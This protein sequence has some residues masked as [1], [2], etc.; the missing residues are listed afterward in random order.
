MNYGEALQYIHSVSWLGSRPG[1]SRISELCRRLSDPERG[2]RFIHVAGTNGKGSVSAE[3]AE[4]LTSAGYR[5]GLFT[6]PYIVDFRERIRIGNEMISE[7]DLAE[8]TDCVKRAA[9]DMSDPP[10]EFELITAVAFEYFKRQGCDFVILEAG[11]G[12]RLDSTNVIK[13]P[14]LSVI[15]G[16]ALDHTAVLGPTVADIAREK[17]GIIKPSCPIVLGD[18]PEKARQVVR[19]RAVECASRLAEVDLRRIAVRGVS[20]CGTDITFAP[21][22]ERYD[23]GG[24]YRLALLGEYQTANAAT[25]LT[26]VEELRREGV[27]IPQEA[28]H[29]GLASTVWHAR[30]EIIARDPTVIYDGAHNPQGMNAA[31]RSIGNLFPDVHPIVL[32]G[33]M[34]D[35]DYGAMADILAPLALSVHTVTPD[36][37]RAMSASELATEF[38]CRGIPTVSHDTVA[39]GVRAAMSEAWA[40]SVPLAVMGSLYMYAD[41][42]AE[43]RKTECILHDGGVAE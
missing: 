19:C 7:E 28:V 33:V 24:D 17:S 22:G 4:I 39:S 23:A 6:S 36:N 40:K 2:L 12:G 26:A 27:A 41:V 16:I 15:T 18:V 30:L 42:S 20:L 32:I 37:P 5:T 3:L 25:V 10:T 14:L 21:S 34:R 13:S 35:K 8:I 29:V 43:V 1:L 9:D 38:R 11:L 31:V